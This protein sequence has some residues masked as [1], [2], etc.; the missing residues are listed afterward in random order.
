LAGSS[1]AAALARQGWQVLLI[2]QDHLPRHKVCGEFLSPEAQHSLRRLDL[3]DDLAVLAPI[4]LTRAALTTARGVAIELPL[5]GQAWG[6]SRYTL[7]AALVAA[8]VRQGAELWPATTATVCTRQDDL[9]TL[10]LR[11]QGEA[12]QVQARAVI[13]ACGRHSRPGLLPQPIPPGR[14]HT[15]WRRCVGLKCHYRQVVM[16]PQVELFLFPGGYVGI[17]PIE[18]GQANVCLLMTYDAFNRS[19]KSVAGAIAMAAAHHSLL[20]QRLN[21]AT[22][23]AGS[24]CTVAPVDTLR[25]AR[26]WAGVACLGDTAAMIPPLSGDGMAMALRSAELCAPPADDFL[27][28]S[29]SLAGWASAYSGAWQAEFKQR[30]GLGRTLQTLLAKPVVGEV[31]V[32]LG[33][34]WPGAADYLVRATRGEG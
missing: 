24:E 28:G 16:P 14:F 19:G 13:M 31:L 25:P 20:A 8:A 23:V 29:L 22:P 18:G 3:Y 34:W 26:P 12:T 6:L 7:D 11:R 10:H 4:P 21:G 5:P 17:N 15:G 30:L 2:E 1:I 33:R 27:R 9:Y 32:G